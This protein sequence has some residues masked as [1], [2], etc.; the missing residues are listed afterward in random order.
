LVYVH[1]NP[2]LWVKQLEIKIDAKA[3]SLDEIDTTA[4]WR[5]E[6]E[7]PITENALDWLEDSGDDHGI[8]T[9]IR[10]FQRIFNFTPSLQVCHQ[11]SESHSQREIGP[12]VALAVD[13]LYQYL[14]LG[15]IC[16]EGL[17]LLLED[18]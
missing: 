2:R 11:Q 6:V 10:M 7:E 16:L 5:V 1:Y 4:A 12:V 9:W 3:I 18:V 17:L 8:R 14:L 13:L 15:D